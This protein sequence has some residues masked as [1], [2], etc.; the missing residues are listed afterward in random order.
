MTNRYR[1]LGD[2]ICEPGSRLMN[3]LIMLLIYVLRYGAPAIMGHQHIPSPLACGSI[4]KML[5]YYPTDDH[6]I[7]MMISCLI[8][9]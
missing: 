7:G 2:A 1:Q 6:K 8:A 3:S 4:L 5:R 9:R